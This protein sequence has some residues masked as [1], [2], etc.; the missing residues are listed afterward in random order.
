MF[1][2]IKK[3]WNYL[4][5][6]RQGQF[7]MLLMLMLFSSLI[8][9]VSLGS[10]L[11]FLGILTSPDIVYSNELLQPVIKVFNIN[12]SNELVLPL[13]IIFILAA[14]IAGF[15][16]IILLYVMTRF[17]FAAGAD[18]SIDIY[19]R[20]LYQDYAVHVRRSSSEI[21]NGVIT[22]TNAVVGGVFSSSLVLINSIVL[23]MA[24][25]V[26]LFFIDALIAISVFIGFGFLY[27]LVI[28]YTR[29]Q[30]NE[31]SKCIAVESTHMIKA[32]QEGLGG[33][34]DILIDGSQ[35]FYCKL[36]RN[37]DAPFRRASANNAFI[38][39]SPRFLMETV[40]MVLIATLAYILSQKEGGI[41]TSIP[42]LGALALGAQ[43]LLPALQQAYKSYSGIKGAQYS[44]DDVLN[45]LEQP[46]PK[47]AN[48]LQ[49]IPVLFEKAIYLKNISY[50]Y[51][52]KTPL[53]IK[54]ASLVINKGKRVGFIGATGSG[55]STLLDIVMGLLIP[56][57]GAMYIDSQEITKENYRSW[58]THIAHVPQNIYLSDSSIE[59]NIAFGVSPSQIDY[60]LVKKA[61][62]QAQISELIEE[63]PE[64]Y[65]AF[66]GERGIRLSGGQRQRIG[67]ARALYKQADVLIF[68]EATSAL[69][70]ETEFAVM[71]A[72]ENLERDLTILIIAH[73]LS[74]LKG[75][76]Q[77]IELSKNGL[78]I[79]EYEEIK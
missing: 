52:N 77:V 55:K 65:K 74:T 32:L 20:T 30:I 16:R 53:V 61:A 34:R 42:V 37:A 36:Y 67:I 41:V 70:N 19:R 50:Q 29:Q 59:E 69:D 60:N 35:Q 49:P 63:W 46:L 27:G 23:L 10:V 25:S 62:K 9:I 64:Q 33:I 22:K 66:V 13:T 21:I 7:W 56:T 75:C 71:E 51:T 15:T 54:N 40:G 47:H 45:L 58:Q 12:N 39:G 73:R 44:F 1:R 14:I 57:K 5:K 3:L 26:T 8:E 76:D 79:R 48:E 18:M 2:Q 17:S 38:G 28:R 31:N 6:R 11:P 72:I 68:D 24:V 4:P 43:R 78:S